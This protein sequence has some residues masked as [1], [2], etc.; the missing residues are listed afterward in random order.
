MYDIYGVGPAQGALVGVGPDGYVDAVACLGD[1][2][3]VDGY[4]KQCILTVFGN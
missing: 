2:H 3:R 1:L 4:L